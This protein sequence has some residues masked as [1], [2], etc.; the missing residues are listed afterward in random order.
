MNGFR[1]FSNR[2][3]GRKPFL[4]SGT[5]HYSNTNWMDFLSNSVIQSFP[6]SLLHMT[7]SMSSS[8]IICD[9]VV[10]PN[11]VWSAMRYFLWAFF[12]M[13]YL[14]RPMHLKY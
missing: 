4:F 12:S 8:G 7:T 9:M 6:S 10:L 5:W 3:L 1:Q 2:G 11:L 14:M 13:R